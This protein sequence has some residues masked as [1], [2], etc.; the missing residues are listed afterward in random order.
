MILTLLFFYTCPFMAP[1]NISESEIR[2]LGVGA[3]TLKDY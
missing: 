1:I 2:E 3:I